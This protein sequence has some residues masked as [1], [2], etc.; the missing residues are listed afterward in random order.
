MDFH[1]P[2][3][4]VVNLRRCFDCTSAASTSTATSAAAAATTATADHFTGK[5]SHCQ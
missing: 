2:L 5:K 1:W 4:T 3:L